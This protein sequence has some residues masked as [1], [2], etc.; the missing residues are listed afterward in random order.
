M[1]FVQSL[2]MFISKGFLASRCQQRL[3]HCNTLL[4]DKLIINSLRAE[5]IVCAPSVKQSKFVLIN[6][7]TAHHWSALLAISRLLGVETDHHEERF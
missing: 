3:M 6:W 7:A 4:G 1:M 5:L 2:S